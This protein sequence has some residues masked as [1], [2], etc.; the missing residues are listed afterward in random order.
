MCIRYGYIVLQ[1]TVSLT[2]TQG[3]VIIAVQKKIQSHKAGKLSGRLARKVIY[4][5]KTCRFDC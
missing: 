1:L 4:A 5:N 2:Y 3:G